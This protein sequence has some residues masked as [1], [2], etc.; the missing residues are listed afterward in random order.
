[1]SAC[2]NARHQFHEGLVKALVARRKRFGQCALIMMPIMDSVVH[3]D[4]YAYVCM[5]Q[6]WQLVK[7]VF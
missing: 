3:D 5:C 1:M 6:D 2:S 7:T 4:N